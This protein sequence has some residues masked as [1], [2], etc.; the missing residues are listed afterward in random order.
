VSADEVFDEPSAWQ[1]D[2]VRR[3]GLD[4][5]DL[6]AGASTG[7]GY[8]DALEP[9]LGG[10]GLGAGSLVLDL[11]AGLGGVSQ[12]VAE[13]TGAIVVALEPERLAAAGADRLFPGLVVVHADA[14][15]TP[16]AAGSFDAVTLFGLVSLV[17]D[18]E[19]L[20]SEVI[21]ILCPLGR[22][23]ISDLFLTSGSVAHPRHSPNT[24]RSMDHVIDRLQLIGCDVVVRVEGETTSTRWDEAGSR[25]DDEITRRHEGSAAL[26]AWQKDRRRIAESIERGEVRVGSVVAARHD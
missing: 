24:F 18:L 23:G 21:R 7:V 4:G 10:L 12:W 16:F 9:V 3:L 2:A 15:R 25:V 19:P 11:G 26:G 6:I 8:P 22:I 1:V 17:E 14:V 5:E 20:L 13:R